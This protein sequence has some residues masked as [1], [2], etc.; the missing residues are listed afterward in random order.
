MKRI[1]EII[2]AI[3]TVLIVRLPS[4]YAQAGETSQN[5]TFRM[6]LIPNETI[7]LVYPIDDHYTFVAAVAP[8][9][10][11]DRGGITIVS[12]T[13]SPNGT[14]LY[15]IIKNDK[16]ESFA[17]KSKMIRGYGEVTAPSNGAFNLSSFGMERGSAAG[18]SAIDLFAEMNVLCRKNNGT[19]V[20]V[21]P[22]SYGIN[23]RLT[24]VSAI[25]AF[26]YVLSSTNKNNSWLMA[27]SGDSKFVVEKDYRFSGAADTASFHAG[28]LLEGVNY[29]EDAST[30]QRREA[31]V[32]TSEESDKTLEATAVEVA[33][34]RTGFVKAIEGSRFVGTYNAA[35]EDT[36]CAQVSVSYVPATQA[37]GTRL[38]SAT[39]YDFKVCNNAVARLGRRVEKDDRTENAYATRLIEPL[40]R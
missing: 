32:M 15:V 33:S 4:A 24:K 10:N 29:V 14:L 5:K 9:M 25:D 20:Y 35:S 40:A 13:K 8:N 12:S 2:A 37:G 17:Y 16:A 11:L 26:S 6:E 18:Y 3:A 22:V 28:R 7:E 1:T 34:M 38:A 30:V 27:C 31:R 19:P 39:I 36:R 21:V 23:K